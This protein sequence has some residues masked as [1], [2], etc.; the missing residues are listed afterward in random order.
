[1]LHQNITDCLSFQ[2]TLM[3]ASKYITSDTCK[4]LVTLQY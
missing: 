1:M 3:D 2:T 4:H